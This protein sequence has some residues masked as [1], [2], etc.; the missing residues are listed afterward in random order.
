MRRLSVRPSVRRV[1]DIWSDWTTITV[2]FH[3][4]MFLPSVWLPAFHPWAFRTTVNT[5]DF[6][7]ALGSAC[8][9]PRY[10]F[11]S[12]MHDNEER[13]R[14]Q[15]NRHVQE[16]TRCCVCFCKKVKKKTFCFNP[17]PSRIPA[18][19]LIYVENDDSFI[20]VSSK[21]NDVLAKVGNF[22]CANLFQFSGLWSGLQQPLHQPNNVC[23][24]WPPL[25]RLTLRLFLS[26]T[27]LFAESFVC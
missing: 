5:F 22:K 12:M 6:W 19:K 1:L 3:K 16:S 7:Q 26:T 15:G 2:T 24:N 27:V 20:M 17:Y 11:A 10:T 21:M 18:G 14:E 25:H 4:N 9:T 8:H 23:I 13:V